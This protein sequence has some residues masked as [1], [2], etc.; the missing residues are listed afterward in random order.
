[1][2]LAHAHAAALSLAFCGW[3]CI[4]AGIAK[5]TVRVLA[6]AAPLFASRARARPSARALVSPMRDARDD[7]V[8]CWCL[9]LRAPLMRSVADVWCSALS[10]APQAL[11]SGQ[12]IASFR[13]F[14]ISGLADLI[15]SGRLPTG[16]AALRILLEPLSS[17]IGQAYS[18]AWWV[19]TF[20]LAAA[21]ATN[22]GSALRGGVSHLLAVL[23]ATTFLLSS[24][25][26]TAPT[27]VYALTHNASGTPGSVVDTHGSHAANAVILFFSGLIICDVANVALLFTLPAAS[28]AAAADAE[29]KQAVTEMLEAPAAAQH[30][31]EVAAAVSV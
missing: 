19:V 8:S 11:L 24:D 4:L 25:V 16:N 22:K 15:H 30:E 9:L 3:V 26:V 28:A 27:G 5:L 7:A 29:L 18:Y 13:N 2:T 12:G 31:E 17:P 14:P 10:T 6:A 20:Q 21:A 23:T 1:M